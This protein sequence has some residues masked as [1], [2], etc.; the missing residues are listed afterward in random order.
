LQSA[1]AAAARTTRKT[2]DAQAVLVAVVRIQRVQA[3]LVLRRRALLAVQALP[4]P[5]LVAVVRQRRVAMTRLLSG[6]RAAMAF[7]Q[8]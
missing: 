1:A 4:A 8:P 3:A 5:V 6:G 2:L 7:H